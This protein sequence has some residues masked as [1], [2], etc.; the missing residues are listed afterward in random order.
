VIG[1]IS[2]AATAAIF[3]NARPHRSAYATQWAD[4]QCCQNKK[5]SMCFPRQGVSLIAPGVA[6]AE[7]GVRI[8]I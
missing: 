4:V 6:L 1:I 3:F 8:I 2:D 5:V 7:P